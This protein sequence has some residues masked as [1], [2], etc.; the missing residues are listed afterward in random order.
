MGNAG[1]G[2]QQDVLAAQ[3]RYMEALSGVVERLGQLREAERVLVQAVRDL[4]EAVAAR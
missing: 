1:D 2:M 4:L 3:D